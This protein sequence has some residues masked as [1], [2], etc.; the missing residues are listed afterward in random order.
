MTSRR[1][2]YTQY[3]AE[4]A[5]FKLALK[6]KGLRDIELAPGW[7]YFVEE[8]EYQASVT[9]CQE[10]RE[11]SILLCFTWTVYQNC[12]QT[13]TCRSQH[14]AIL[15][16]NI[17]G[18]KDYKATGTG[19]VVCGRHSLVCKNGVGDLQKGERLVQGTNYGNYAD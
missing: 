14:N 1:W 5:N 9:A 16:A 17:R 7:G 12:L 18:S 8:S 11:V 3:L 10:D 6:E 19:A 4:D 13:N 15:A 2:P